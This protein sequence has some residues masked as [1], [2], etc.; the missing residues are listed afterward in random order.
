MSSKMPSMSEPTR[1]W[2]FYIDDMIAFAERVV[3]YTRGLDQNAFETSPLHQDATLRNLE[4]IG[5]AATHIPTD[6]RALYPDIP[7]RRIVAT[8]NRLIHAYL[9]IDP[10]TVWSIV[11][12]DVPSLLARLHDMKNRLERS[13]RQ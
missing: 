4:L 8:R 7:W 3:H 11:R 10:D 9:G 6:I 13:S 5:E 2:A 12:D 1:A